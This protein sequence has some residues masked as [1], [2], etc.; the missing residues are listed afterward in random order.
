MSADPI[1]GDNRFEQTW[2]ATACDVG[3]DAGFYCELNC[4]ELRDHATCGDV[5]FVG[6]NQTG[7]SAHVAYE[8]DDFAFRILQTI[9]ARQNDEQIGLDE[10]GHLSREPVVVAEIEFFNGDGV[11]FVDDWNDILAGKKLE[12]SIA[13]VPMA[14]PAIEIGMRE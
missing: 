4:L 6:T 14:R 9:D 12:E 7:N 10:N 2:L 1:A 8:G 13:G 11:I 3:G 5:A